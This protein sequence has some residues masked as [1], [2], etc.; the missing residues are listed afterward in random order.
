MACRQKLKELK[1]K[2]IFGLFLSCLFLL[3][4]IGFLE[5]QKIKPEEGVKTILNGKKPTPPPGRQASAR[6]VEELVI[7]L[8]ENPEEALAEVAGFDIDQAGNIIVLDFKEKK[9]KV[10]DQ[11][12]K[13]IRS[14]GRGGQGPGEFEIPGGLILTPSGEIMVEDAGRRSFQFFR[15]TGELSRHFSFAEKL[16]L[17]GT[18]LDHQGNFIARELGFTQD[19]MF[20]EIKK[21][22]PQLKP[23]FSI[24]KVEFPIPLPGSGKKVNFA[25]LLFGYQTDGAGNIYYCRNTTYEIK[26]FNSEGK[27]LHSIQKK[28]DRVK[29][30]PEDKKEIL[31]RMQGVVIGQVNVQEMFEFPDYFPPLQSFLVDKEGWIIVQTFQKGKLK[32]E[33]ENDVFDGEGRLVTQF[34]SKANISR[35]RGDKL[36]GVE[37]TEDGLRVI[38]RFRLVW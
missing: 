13:L 1:M 7:G 29:I 32:G 18:I 38:K 34:I 19:K 16:N 26:V 9:I 10:F 25:D 11:K 4:G 3:R 27:H 31:E 24:D 37:E 36:Y 21:Y 20:Y 6:L 22:D 28:Y 8:S 23:L 12:G 30:T 33:Y 17:V 35:W 15:T 5:A 2:P 14:F